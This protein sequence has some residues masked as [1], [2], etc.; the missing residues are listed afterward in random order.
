MIVI[1]RT[2]TISPGK[3]KEA[4]EHWIKVIK[5][6][7]KLH[8]ERKYTVITRLTGE[9]PNR[10]TMFSWHDSVAAWGEDLQEH[11]ADPELKALMNEDKEKQYTVPDTLVRT[12]HEVAE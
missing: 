7:N 1:T 12:L 6:L 8:P 5:H 11:R 9:R 4:I 2:A 3:K 10:I